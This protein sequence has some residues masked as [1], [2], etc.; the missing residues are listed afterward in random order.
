[1]L[2]VGLTGGIGA[3]KST[4]STR[5]AE[6]GATIV[7]A[8]KIAREVV[9]PGTPGL[10]ELVE[11]FGPE[12]LTSDGALDRPALAA[13]AFSNDQSRATLNSI[14]HPRVGA[15]TAEIIAAAPP[16]GILIHDIP[17]L[18]EN[19][20]APTCHLVLVVHAEEDQRVHRLTSS[21]GM[22]EAD[23]RARIAAQATDE[24][25]R[26]AADIWLDNTEDREHLLQQVTAAWHDRLVPFERNLRTRT[27]VPPPIVPSE[28]DL[29]WAA[30]AARLVARLQ[31]A[32]G[33]T[34]ATV[35]HIG[36]TAVAGLPAPDAIDIQVAV[37]DQGQADELADRLAEAGFPRADSASAPRPV[38]D[39]LALHAN[40]DPGRPAI[41]QV[42]VAGSPGQRVAIALRDMLRADPE[43]REQ[44]A[45]RARRAAVGEAAPLDEWIEHARARLS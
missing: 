39:L 28:P 27:P 8:D 40:A 10:A 23:A 18:I 35:E 11:A 41:V 32:C 26:A 29:E 21:R 3:G 36:P 20:L 30:Q 31:L 44:Y 6:L 45:D 34:S 13:V 2:R 12:I 17:L 24:Q 16:D 38:T 19:G 42:Q 5:L 37:A 15:R 25:R 14:V 22:P 33:G 9:E 4:V 7:D 43:A 1:M